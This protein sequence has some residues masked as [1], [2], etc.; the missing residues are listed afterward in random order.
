MPR[1]ILQGENLINNPYYIFNNYFPSVADAGKDNI[2]YFQKHFQDYLNNHCN[3][4]IFIQST[5]SQKKA[6][7]ISALNM[8]KS[9][10]LNIIPLKIINLFK[11]IFQNDLQI[12][13]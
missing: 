2:M 5:D 1:T 8:N 12:Y 13:F 11:K 7:I 6:N 4:S 10:G 9:S 3:N